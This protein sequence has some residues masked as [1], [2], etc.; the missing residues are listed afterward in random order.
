VRPGGGL[1]LKIDVAVAGLPR[2]GKTLFCINFAEYMGAR[3]LCY[4][5]SGPTGRGKGVVTPG[6]AREKMVYAGAR[7]NGVVRG[8][9]VNLLSREP[10]RLLLADTAALNATNP[11]SKQ[12]RRSLCFTLN[13]LQEADV[14]LYLMELPCTDPVKI[15]FA[16]Q[17][18]LALSGYCLRHNKPYLLVGT[19]L[20]Q[21]T[22]SSRLQKQI[23]CPNG[24]LFKLSSVTR[25]GFPDLRR[26]L[27]KCFGLIPD[28]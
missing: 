14:V 28:R 5:Q 24:K 15:D 13:A 1:K 12:D 16:L 11:L 2:V 17:V 7:L 25:E 22:G 4:T 6:E 27:F 23:F 8:F 18:N 21:L 26:I 9:V 19:K 10:I 3:N 20:D